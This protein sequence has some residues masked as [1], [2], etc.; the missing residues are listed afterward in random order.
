MAVRSNGGV[1]ATFQSP[2]LGPRKWQNR[3]QSTLQT[4]GWP[5]LKI[6]NAITSSTNRKH[7]PATWKNPIA[8]RLSAVRVITVD[9]SIIA[10]H[11][12]VITRSALMVPSCGTTAVTW[13][14]TIAFPPPPNRCLRTPNADKLA[15][16]I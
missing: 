10:A 5:A 8:S 2:T 13:T 14:E 16:L 3:I 11:L 4:A 15:K 6:N 12:V 9:S 1:I 7:W